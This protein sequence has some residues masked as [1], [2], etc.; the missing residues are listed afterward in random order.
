MGKKSQRPI[1]MWPL[2]KSLALVIF[3]IFGLSFCLFSG[4]KNKVKRESNLNVLLVTLDTTRADHIGI[5]GYGKAKTTTIDSLAL[6]GVKFS[7][8]YCPVPMTLPSHCSIMTGTYPLYHKVHNNGTYHLNKEIVTLA[9]RLKEKGYKTSA[10]VSSFNVD[11]RFGVD[12]GFDVYDDKFGE[13]EMIKTFRS[14]RS[15]GDT[16]ASFIRC[17]EGASNEK[18]FSW[19]HLYD[20]HLPY[21]PPSPFKEE[22]AGIPYDGE[23]AYMDFSLGK[24]IEKLK[25]KGL[26][27]KT[28]IVI[29]GDHGEALGEKEEVD[30][31]V[32]IYDV[33]MR[34]PLIF[35]APQNLP[36][37]LVVDSRVRLIDI[38]PSVLDMLKMPVNKEV[39]G[40]SLLPY[41]EGKKKDNLTCYLES[42]YPLETYGWSEL[43]GLIDGDWKYIQAPRSELYNLKVDKGEET[44][45]FPKEA[46][47][48]SALKQ[49][50]KELIDNYSSKLALSRRKMSQ[51]EEERLRSLGYVG[52]DASVRVSKGPL[53]DP[54]DMM[55][56]FRILYQAVQSEWD[57]KM[58][59]AEKYYRE[60]LRLMP[61]VAW[62]YL[63]LAIFLSRVNRLPEAI[64]VLKQG[65][66]RLPDSFVLLS[67]LAH[68]YMRVGK[69][70]ESFDMSQAALRIDPQYFDALVIAGSIQDIRGKWEESTKYYKK[71]LEIEPENK[72]IRL[73]YAYALG[74]LGR[75]EEAVAIDEA[76]KKESPK[77]YRI[78]QDL[79]V[80]YTSLGK[81]DQAEENLKKSVELNPSPE[82]YLNYAVILERAGK[83]PEAINYLKLYIEKTPEGETPRKTNARKALAEWERRLR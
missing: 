5:Y 13:D 34:I 16:A 9:Q 20:P 26:L 73:K 53:A 62:R 22:F 41:I 61:D 72:M 59:E 70:Q 18:F 37:G 43:V 15:A 25:E 50:L 17:L 60:I 35:Y 3:F 58:A 75:Q 77:D 79:G 45:L 55:G 21:H 52:A 81:L 46:K 32:F 27:D 24:I 7:N 42:Y 51:E 31:G 30:H 28:L 19:V 83:L 66:T 12:K 80:I 36:Q 2:K 49:R 23:I 29:A 48:A 6:K 65:L 64:E 1:G 33:T 57:G 76:L 39:Q 38:M 71:A 4:A 63:D 8:A 47:T 67:R 40:E 44:N 10:F 74:A 68:F 78:Y 14:E 11:S 56:E 69:Y 54:K 82:T